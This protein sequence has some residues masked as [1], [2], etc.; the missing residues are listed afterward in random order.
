MA[1]PSLLP[2]P[3]AGGPLAIYRRTVRISGVPHATGEVQPMSRIAL[4]CIGCI[5]VVAIEEFGRVADTL[6]RLDQS[7]QV[8]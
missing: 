4:L 5:L 3:E 7:C 1:F 8:R 6:E 2:D